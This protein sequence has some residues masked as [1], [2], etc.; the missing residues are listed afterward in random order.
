MMTF[1]LTYGVKAHQAIVTFPSGAPEGKDIQA[2]GDRLAEG[3]W[4][5]RGGAELVGVP[6]PTILVRFPVNGQTFAAPLV[7]SVPLLADPYGAARAIV[8]T[9]EGM[10][11]QKAA[12]LTATLRA[13]GWIGS[14]G[15]RSP[16]T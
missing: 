7:I 14:F 12:E 10:G 3:G 15:G 1:E 2:L 9:A 4:Q 8:T 11:R 16:V 13:E 5:I 6:H